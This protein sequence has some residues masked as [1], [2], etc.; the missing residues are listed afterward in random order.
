MPPPYPQARPRSGAEEPPTVQAKSG[1]GRQGL[2]ASGRAG[3]SFSPTSL[4]IGKTPS[5]SPTS[6]KRPKMHQPITSSTEAAPATAAAIFASGLDSLEPRGWGKGR[7]REGR[8][9]PRTLKV[10]GTKW[11]EQAVARETQPT[12]VP[13]QWVGRVQSVKDHSG[14]RRDGD[15]VTSPGCPL[16]RLCDCLSEGVASQQG[17]YLKCNFI[18]PKLMDCKS[19]R[20]PGGLYWVYLEIQGNFRGFL[21]FRERKFVP[22]AKAQGAV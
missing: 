15:A 9:R 3:P 5:A 11:V 8:R 1:A 2:P 13:W 19:W 18:P 6:S 4:N 21:F 22:S 17:N 14:P 12:G 20:M 10:K 7:E 16:R